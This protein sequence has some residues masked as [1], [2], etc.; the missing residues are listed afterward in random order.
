MYMVLKPAPNLGWKGAEFF[1]SE[2]IINTD[3]NISPNCLMCSEFDMLLCLAWKALSFTRKGVSF[4][5]CISLQSSVQQVNPSS[6]LLA[7]S[8]RW[9]AWSC[10]QW[11]DGPR[12]RGQCFKHSASLFSF[13]F[14]WMF[15]S[16]G[17]S[18][19]RITARMRNNLGVLQPI[20]ILVF[21]ITFQIDSY[22]TCILPWIWQDTHG[23]AN[24]LTLPYLL[25]CL[26]LSWQGTTQL[27]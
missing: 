2:V 10:R 6:F 19:D 23:V 17:K 16:R 3:I 8:W 13:F 7:C 14:P 24:S 22:T 4:C 27:C 11:N 25:F 1:H 5:T 21:N 20:H 9:W 12:A 26:C 15:F 18:S